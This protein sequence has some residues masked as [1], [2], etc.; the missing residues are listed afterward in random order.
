MKNSLILVLILISAI[1]IAAQPLGDVI[2]TTYLLNQSSGPSGS[3]IAVGDDGSIY[4]CWMNLL[5]GPYPPVIRHIY[6]NWRSPEG[7]WYSDDGCQV[8]ENSGAGY[9]NLDII[10]GN[11][12]CFTYHYDQN[13]IIAIEWDPPGMG[14]FDYFNVPNEIFPQTPDY[15]GIC[16]WPQITVD[17]NA[18][19]VFPQSM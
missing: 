10:D 12:G 17:R 9:C 19:I 2:G 1:S 14:F 6:Y 8:S 5:G 15:P 18:N 16:L 7:E 4:A 3:R 11:R 13:V